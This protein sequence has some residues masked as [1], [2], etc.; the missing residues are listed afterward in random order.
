MTGKHMLNIAFYLGLLMQLTKL[1]DL[2]FRK[3]QKQAIQDTFDILT[4]KLDRAN[5]VR[6][7]Y[8]IFD[9]RTIRFFLWLI[10][11]VFFILILLV[12]MME[13]TIAKYKQVS[14]QG[15]ISN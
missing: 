11:S 6:Y 14:S 10:A 8:L 15:S 2:L 4:L 13:E 1:S 12:N 3:H 9:N 5:P 7:F